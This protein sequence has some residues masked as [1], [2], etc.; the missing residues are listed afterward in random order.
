MTQLGAPKNV[1]VTGATGFIGQHLVPLLLRNNINVTALGRDS[2]KSKCIP[3]I[4]D[5]SFISIDIASEC[6]RLCVDRETGIIHLAWDRLDDYFCLS[7]IED[8]LPTSY[9]FLKSLVIRGVRQ[10]LVAGTCFEYGNMNGSIKSSSHCSPI[11]PYGYAKHAL[12]QQL[13]FLRTAEPFCLQWARLFYIYG[14]GQ[15]SNSLFDQLDKAIDDNTPFF[16]MTGGEQLRDYLSVE[17]V[18]Q[19]IFELYS[20]GEDGNFNICSGKPVSIRKL[21]E[22]HIKHRNSEIKLN[23]GYY[24]YS[25]HEPMAFWGKRDIGDTR[26]LPVLPNAP[27]INTDDN[28]TLGP[29]RLRRNTK[30][31]FIENEAFEDGLIN[32]SENYENSQAHSVLFTQHMQSVTNLLKDTFP[33]GSSLVEVGCGKGDFLE[34]VES[35]GHF[36][37]SGYD[38]S[39]NGNHPRIYKRYLNSSDNLNADVVIIRHV[40]EHVKDPYMFLFML[41]H[42]FGDANVYIEVPNL[43]WIIDNETFYDITYEHVNYFSQKSLCMLFDQITF[44]SGLLFNEQYQYVLTNF[45]SLSENFLRYYREDC[46]DLIS[47]DDLFPNIESFVKH[48]EDLSGSK[49]IY[50]WGAATKGTLLLAHFMNHTKLIEKVRFA[51]DQ[52]PQ[53]IG[54][55]IPGSQVPI[56]SREEFASTVRSG[57]L[58]LVSNRNYLKEIN[59]FIDECSIRDIKIEAL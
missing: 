36:E 46:W 56:K 19:Q 21:V 22:E 9:H 38:A 7:H 45:G 42:V 33:Y 37:T 58:L 59:E 3:W 49:H 28:H 41:K 50:I 57:D 55:Y 48:I 30:L 5:V 34:M 2:A 4:D 18:A 26:Y 23:Q 51:I 53:K 17:D 54:R 40:L 44:S 11:T 31:D 10:V 52:N 32:Y 16:N 29:I 43:N 24:P 20:R 12:H 25:K 47:F 15:K 35:D 39:Y 27:L 1:I 13:L 14:T 8:N 6:D